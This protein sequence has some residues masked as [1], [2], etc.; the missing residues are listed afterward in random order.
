VRERLSKGSAEVVHCHML[1]HLA[2]PFTRGRKLVQVEGAL[3]RLIDRHGD[4]NYLGRE[5]I[6]TRCFGKNCPTRRH[7]AET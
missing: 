1:F 4:G 2:H 6:N 7:L 5:L 3:E